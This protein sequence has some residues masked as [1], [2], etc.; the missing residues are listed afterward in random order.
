M[1]EVP[2]LHVSSNVVVPH[3]FVRL[4]HSGVG[5]NIA[6]DIIFGGGGDGVLLLLRSVVCLELQSPLIS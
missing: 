2:H 3:N 1:D 4:V 6:N 5:K